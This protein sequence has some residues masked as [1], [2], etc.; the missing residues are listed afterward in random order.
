MASLDHEF[1]PRDYDFPR[2]YVE[3]E[4]SRE[5]MAVNLDERT[6]RIVHSREE[7]RPGERLAG[8]IPYEAGWQLI[9]DPVRATV[10]RPFS[11]LLPWADGEA[12]YAP[13]DLTL[14]LVEVSGIHVNLIAREGEEVTQRDVL[15][16]VVTGK[17]ETR[18][19]RAETDGIILYIAWDPGA[20][21]E[22]YIYLITEPEG[23]IILKP[24][25]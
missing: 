15:A 20:K 5:Y 22:R 7:A 25:G 19:I 4:E 24:S 11:V 14:R 3:G 10:T 16:Y 17:G 12:L 23:I 6:Y 8:L 18:T 21:P 2:L 1:T 13:R 9:F